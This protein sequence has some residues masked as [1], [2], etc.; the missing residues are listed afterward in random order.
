MTPTGRHLLAVALLL[1]GCAARPPAPDPAAARRDLMQADRDFAAATAE[2]G[3]EGWMDAY[4]ADAVRLTMGGAVARGQQEIRVFDAGIFE[5]PNVRLSW[6]PTDG[7]GFGDGRHG[8][9]TGTSHMHPVD[10]PADTLWKGNYVTF[11]RLEPDGRWR[12]ILDTG[13]SDN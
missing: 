4:T 12:V 7:G 3:M 9:T 13:A 1:A 6:T 8:W 2:R 5:D 10:A 11:W